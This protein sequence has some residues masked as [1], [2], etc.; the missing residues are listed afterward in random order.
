MTQEELLQI[1][2]ALTRRI[3]DMEA[4]EAVQMNIGSGAP[5]HAAAEG[6]LYW[7]TSANALYANNNGST[8]WTAV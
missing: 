3:E 4:Q 7:D 5:S 8:G 1:I 2:A 6:T